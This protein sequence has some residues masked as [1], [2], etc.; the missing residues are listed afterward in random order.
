MSKQTAEYK[1]HYVL[2]TKYPDELDPRW[3]NDPEAIYRDLGPRPPGHVIYR[4]DR[5][6][7]WSP[8]NCRWGSRMEAGRHKKG[9]VKYRLPGQPAP[10]T[11]K[12]ASER[13]N[14]SLACLKSRVYNLGLTI[15]EAVEV[16]VQ[17]GRRKRLSGGPR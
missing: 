1:T 14:I 3:K 11:L 5:S 6:K 7:P 9:T 8:E 15:E 2:I 17:S 12:E 4:I 13:Y 10:L 16:P